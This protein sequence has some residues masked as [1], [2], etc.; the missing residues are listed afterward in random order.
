MLPLRFPLGC[1]IRAATGTT[2]IADQTE[3]M[4]RQICKTVHTW[5]LLSLHLNLREYGITTFA[6]LQLTLYY[7]K[8]HF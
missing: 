7:Q 3:I 1:A 6:L 5:R 2:R 8:H 4:L